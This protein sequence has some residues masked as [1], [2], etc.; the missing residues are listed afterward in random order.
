VVAG[1]MDG[2]Q[3]S[4]RASGERHPIDRSPESVSQSSVSHQSVIQGGKEKE[5]PGA[6]LPNQPT[7]TGH[8]DVLG[9]P[10]GCHMVAWSG[11]R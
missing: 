4:K 6:C 8:A 1:R 11:E 3:P 10:H 7:T 9:F 2:W 5:G